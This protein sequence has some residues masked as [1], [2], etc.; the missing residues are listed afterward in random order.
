M[1]KRE[2][3]IL[4]VEASI[5]LTL[6]LLFILFL[7]SFGRVY[8]AQNLVSHATLQSA[9]AVAL[10]SYLRE[11]ALQTDV[12]EVVHLASHI[13]ESSAISAESLES[14]RS[15]NLPKIARQKF[16][17]AIAS[18][19]A[20]ADEKL[21][22]MGVKN[23]LAGVDFSECKMDLAN[24]DVIIAIRY[25][26]EMQFPVFGFNEI[27]VTKA[28]K[29]KTFGEILFEVSTEPN[30]PGWGSTS[31]D[32]KV[33]HGS[34]VQ[35]TA[36]PNYG[37]KFVSWNDGNTDNPR[38]VTVTDAQHYIAIFEKDSFGI[39]LST[40]IT[41]NTSYAGISHSSYGSVAGAGNY[42]YLENATI[43]ATPAT[44]YQFVGWD[45]NGDG[46]VDNTNATRTIT[47]DKTYDIKAIFKPAMKTVSV[48]A[49][50]GTYG[51]VQVSQGSNKGSSIQV[52]YG[53]KVQLLASSNDAEKYS[54]I[55]WSNSD[56]NPTPTITVKESAT[57]EAIFNVNTYTVT[58]YNGNTKLH[59]TTVIRGCSIDAS[60]ST[61]GSSMY[62]GSVSDFSRWALSSGS[63]FASSTQVKSNMVANN[64]LNV[65]AVLNCKIV[66]NANGGSVTWKSKTVE[67]GTNVS[68]PK[69]TLTGHTFKG[70]KGS[71][72]K[73]YSASSY[74]FSNNITLTA[75]WACDETVGVLTGNIYQ[76]YCRDIYSGGSLKAGKTLPWREYKCEKCGHTWKSY[77]DSLRLHYR[78]ND[79]SGK[80]D[81][82]KYC[83][84]KHSYS[85]WRYCGKYASG[86]VSGG[87]HQWDGYYHIMCKYCRKEEQGVVY[88]KIN[89]VWEYRHVL[90]CAKHG[91]PGDVNCPF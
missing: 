6:M 28:A 74:K 7:F 52:E 38:T 65:Y 8:R 29:A 77:N 20:K 25:T 12:S 87:E 19:E 58:F 35:I 1:K 10:E 81:F 64:N 21:K 72:G 83:N 34:T 33:V 45:D 78:M 60:K 62:S 41:Y 44:N 47:V 49:N 63:T 3:G 46:T 4:T 30:Q 48:K 40:R 15:A 68:L 23:G 67:R 80:D 36:T 89:G 79:G 5:V 69:P 11:T 84:K 17:A 86:S 88:I 53:S 27:T 91:D 61:L 43:S 54:F 71:D 32:D 55:K 51:A 24:D 18:S 16:I 37:Y 22:S 42:L 75:Q 73:S 82:N 13:T 76:P 26:I 39:N 59:T 14:L 31:G 90:R 9:D 2:Q 66:L 85:A 57:Y 56:T 70:W 50:N